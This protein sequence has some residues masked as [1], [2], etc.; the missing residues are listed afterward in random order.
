MRACMGWVRDLEDATGVRCACVVNGR[1]AAK[2]LRLR[3][4]LA[5]VSKQMLHSATASKSRLR[6]H[7]G[8]VASWHRGFPR[9]QSCFQSTHTQQREEPF[10]SWTKTHPAW[11]C[12]QLFTS[13]PRAVPCRT[14]KVDAPP[15]EFVDFCFQLESVSRAYPVSALAV[16]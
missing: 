14:G 9:L 11:P 13:R 4:R 12:Q 16:H 8:I 3:L 15:K 1:T 6:R 5:F 7:C 10:C 2:G